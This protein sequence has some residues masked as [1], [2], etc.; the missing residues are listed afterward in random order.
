MQ[1]LNS[2][3]T[4]LCTATMGFR[5]LREFLE[6]AGKAGFSAVSLSPGDYKSARQAGCNDKEIERLLSDNGLRIADLDGTVDWLRSPPAEQGAGYTLSHPFFGHSEDDFFALADRFGARSLN[7]VDPFVYTAPLE[8]MTA[9]FAK[10]CDRAMSH[11]LLVH[12]EF[13]SWGPAPNL[14]TAWD[15]VRL[16][17]RDNGGLMLDALH[18]ARGGGREILSL[19]PGR[20]ILATQLCD[21]LLNTDQ[22]AFD[23]AANRMF[24]GQGEF[25][26]VGLV[27]ELDSLQCDAPIGVETMN[28]QTATMSADQ[29]AALSYEALS[30]I[31]AAARPRQTMPS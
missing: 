21:G 25:D 24:P 30:T 15:I 10:L 18:L 13:L 29:L 6:A 11:G 14:S 8:E 22:N 17:D 3:S 4:V 28:A 12:L 20:K 1:E 26:I 31:L 19:I 9:A 16:A 7:A 5:P 27:Q 23:D 2:N